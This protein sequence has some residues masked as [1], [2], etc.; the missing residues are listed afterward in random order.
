MAYKVAGGGS[1]TKTSRENFNS[2][3]GVGSTVG[4]EDL[5]IRSPTTPH[6]PTISPKH[7]HPE[8]ILE[9]SIF[10]TKM[11]GFLS[12]NKALCP[13]LVLIPF[14]PLLS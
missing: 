12:E 10:L 3:K 1:R 6:R 5:H 8:W 7:H 14:F 13:R 4:T 2:D 9:V 11:V